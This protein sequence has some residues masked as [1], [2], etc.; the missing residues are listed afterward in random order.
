M[1][2]TALLLFPVFVLNQIVS[3]GIH[4][5]LIIFAFTLTFA[6]CCSLFTNARKQEVFGAA[7][8]YCAVLVIFLGNTVGN[9][10]LE[11]GVQK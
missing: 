7:A 6:A 1:I 3:N 10:G 2:A 9:C 11:S 4:Q 5:L 8:G